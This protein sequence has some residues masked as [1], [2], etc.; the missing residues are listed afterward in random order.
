MDILFGV[1]S[2]GLGALM[3]FSGYILARILLPLWG[4]FAGF[5]IGAAGAADAFNAAFIG[6]TMGIV[7]GLIVGLVF[8]LCAYFFY[9]LAVVLLGASLGYWV[10]TGLLSLIGIDKGFLSALV[11]ITIGIVFAIATIG[12]N[13]AKYLLIAL[14]SFAG[15]LAI[16]KGLLLAFGKIERTNLDYI[17]TN[18]Q[19]IDNNVLWVV[20]LAVLVIIGIISQIKT[21]KT[22]Y[23]DSWTT[24]Y[25]APKQSTNSYKKDS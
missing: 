20:A 2:I 16:I 24:A 17:T 10:G 4:F 8:A 3:L 21:T 25:G 18:T 11:G 14:T 15:G 7:V 19:A 22:T 9:S 6:T 1:I 13:A 5:T 23:L 12:F